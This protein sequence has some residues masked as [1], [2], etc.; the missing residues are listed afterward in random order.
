MWR[1][2]KK[3]LSI[4]KPL[5]DAKTGE[6][7]IWDEERKVYSKTLYAYTIV[8]GQSYKEAKYIYGVINLTKE[9]FELLEAKDIF[10]EQ[11]YRNEFSY[12]TEEMYKVFLK[13]YSG[14]TGKVVEF[15]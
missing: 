10:S 3:F 9:R 2:K 6:L 8:P 15:K 12:I 13:E 14:K 1:N 5:T 11:L 7:W 4:I